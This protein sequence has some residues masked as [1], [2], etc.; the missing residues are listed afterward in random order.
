MAVVFNLKDKSR[1]VSSVRVVVSF[2]G[3]QFRR[4]TGESV[5]V[6]SW[7][8]TAQRCKVSAYKKAE[9]VNA[10][11][12]ELQ[13][14]IEDAC[15]NF[16]AQRR[17]PSDIELWAEVDRIMQGDRVVA[18]MKFL[19]YFAT[20]LVKIEGVKAVSTCKKY[21]TTF[22]KLSDYQDITGKKLRFEDIDIRF[23]QAFEKYI[24]GMDYSANYF[25][26]L[27]KCIK[28]VFREARDI[29]GLH[30]LDLVENKK[31]KVVSETADTIYLTEEELLAIHNLN[32]TEEMVREKLS[33]YK[34]R[35]S[36]IRKKI[37]WMNIARN[38]FLI[39][40]FT[41]LRVS[42]FNQL[43]AVNLK[44]DYIK[45]KTQKTLTPVTIPIH[46]VIREIL[47]SGFKVDTKMSDQKINK[48]IKD[49]ARLADITELVEVTRTAGGKVV[50]KNVEKCLLVSTHTAR[51]SGA[52]NMVKFGI[53]ALNVMKITGH[54]KW[55]S[56]MKY[57]KLDEEE[58]AEVIK[59]S[60]FFDKPKTADDAGHESG[61]K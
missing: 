51:R 26:S 11:L 6:K 53:P 37:Y 30:N 13:R 5:P 47:A 40:A 55:N 17:L 35:S 61:H 32:I 56:F 50:R 23:Y 57:V 18:K 4:S 14:A 54:S 21:Q 36:D 1:S 16:T 60:G 34:S 2:N 7:S 59:A 29:D 25:G 12:N 41:A 48:Q 10:N 20:Y 19:E 33:M 27:V 49:V 38:K 43:S 31:F 8:T 39:G 22:N 44:D 24:Y 15:D 52:T 28:V 58:N 9:K 42:D 3:R 46:W 45:V